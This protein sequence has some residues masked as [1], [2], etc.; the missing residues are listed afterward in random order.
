MNGCN[1]ESV[2]EEKDLGVWIEDDLRPTKQCK[3]AAQSANWA[4]GQLTRAFHFRKASCLVPL[5]KTFV[6]PKLEH[7]VAAWS[8]W[9]EG[10]REV[11]ERVQ[12]RLVRFVSDKKGMTYEE[13]LES[14]GLT[15][16]VER[17]ERGDLIEAFKTLKGFNNVE[18]DNWFGFRNAQGT[19]ATRST[20][21]IS[22]DGQQDREDVLFMQ[23]VR[24][25]SR[26]H[27]FTMRTVGKW[28]QL[29]DSVKC[30]RTINSFKNH[31]DEWIRT[32]KRRR[33]QQQT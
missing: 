13:R 15:T 12:K 19:R 7:A 16:L 10:D 1:I 20:V 24:L 33:Q 32:E 2:K 11:L 26:K 31:Y 17:R 29:P 5:Y 9:M 18:K 14:I 28:N 21:S 4:L 25:E 6:R 30:Q 8:P 22:D 3:M 27:F 23:N